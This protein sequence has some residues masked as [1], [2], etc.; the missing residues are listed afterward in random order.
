MTPI[1][2]LLRILTDRDDRCSFLERFARMLAQLAADHGATPDEI[3]AVL[4]RARRR[5][6]R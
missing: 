1:D 3:H 5:P 2:G 6:R 4:V